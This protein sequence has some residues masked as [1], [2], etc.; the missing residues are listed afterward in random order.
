M[1]MHRMILSIGMFLVLG[2][3]SVT[4]AA[5]QNRVLI[6]NQNHQGVLEGVV[7][8]VVPMPDEGKAPVIALDVLPIGFVLPEGLEVVGLSVTPRSVD[9]LRTALLGKRVRLTY[10]RSTRGTLDIQSIIL[11]PT[12]SLQQQPQRDR[13]MLLE[14][15]NKDLGGSGAWK[16]EESSPSP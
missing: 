9:R 14:L 13:R 4:S 15:H 10:K 6:E 2:C 3:L 11:L 1:A 5:A 7:D 16:R 8:S 12:A